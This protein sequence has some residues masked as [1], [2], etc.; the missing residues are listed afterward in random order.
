MGDTE[1]GGV[2][3]TTERRATGRGSRRGR[4]RTPGPGAGRGAGA[5]AGAVRGWGEAGADLER[6]SEATLRSCDSWS[7]SR[8]RMRSTSSARSCAHGFGYTQRARLD[9]M[10][11]GI[12]EFS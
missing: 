2:V 12:A 7:A 6:R 1:A 4:D 10:M 8:A 9:P 3:A 5:G 11:L